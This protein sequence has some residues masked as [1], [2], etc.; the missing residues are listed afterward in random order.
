MKLIYESFHTT[1]CL[2]TDFLLTAFHNVRLNN[3]YF[4]QVT[5]RT[6]TGNSQTVQNICFV[7]V[8]VGA[9]SNQNSS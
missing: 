6:F 7:A 9:D 1:L 4:L 5:P 8:T 3:Y 2:E